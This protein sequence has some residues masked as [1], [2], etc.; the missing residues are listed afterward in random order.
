[1][2]RKYILSTSLAAGLVAAF[3]YF[4]YGS[5]QTPPGQAPLQNLTPQ[6]VGQLKDAFNAAKSDVRVLLLLSPT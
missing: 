6:N 2:K 1:M 3:L 5:G 4:F